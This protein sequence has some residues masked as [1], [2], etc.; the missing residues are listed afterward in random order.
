MELHNLTAAIPREGPALAEVDPVGYQWGGIA[1]NA[2]EQR[3]FSHLKASLGLDLPGKAR[4]GLAL[5]RVPSSL[6]SDNLFFHRLHLFAPWADA[7]GL[8]LWQPCTDSPQGAPKAEGERCTNATHPT[9]R[10]TPSPPRTRRS[11][12]TLSRHQCSEAKELRSDDGRRWLRFTDD[13]GQCKPLLIFLLLCFV[14]AHRLG[15]GV[16]HCLRL[17]RT[18]KGDRC[19]RRKAKGL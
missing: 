2:P 14:L 4:V 9:R 7:N 17:G 15:L 11:V 16:Q 19:G 12:K 5:P 10:S 13:R 1:V 8:P 3:T 6:F 18:S